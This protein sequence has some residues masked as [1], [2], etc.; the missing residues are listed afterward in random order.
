MNARALAPLGLL[1]LL[2]ACGPLEDPASVVHPG[3]EPGPTATYTARPSIDAHLPD[4]FMTVGSFTAEVDPVAGTVEFIEQ[5][6]RDDLLLAT[7]GPLRTVGQA[8]YCQ[9]T[10]NPSS[11]NAGFGLDSVAGTIGFSP[12][13]CGADTSNVIYQ[14]T[15]VFCFDAEVTNLSEN[16]RAMDVFAIIN[17]VDPDDSYAPHVFS[18]GVQEMYGANL[19][20]LPKFDTFDFDESDAASFPDQP[21]GTRPLFENLRDPL[22]VFDHGFLLPGESSVTSW[23]FRNG[24]GVFRFRGKLVAYVPEDCDG[25]DNDCDGLIDEGP[26]NISE[27][28]ACGL[29]AELGVWG[30]EIMHDQDALDSSGNPLRDTVDWD[31][32]VAAARET[33][34]QQFVI[35]VPMVSGSPDVSDVQ[36]LTDALDAANYN[37]DIVVFFDG[38]RRSQE[39]L[40]PAYDLA[41]WET[42]LNQAIAALT[43]QDS[44]YV[45][46]FVINQLNRDLCRPDRTTNCFDRADIQRFTTAL[47]ASMSGR[48]LLHLA[49]LPNDYSALAYFGDGAR[50]IYTRRNTAPPAGTRKVGERYGTRGTFTLPVSAT[51][52]PES[53]VLRFT[54]S[55]Q[56]WLGV[57][58]ARLIVTAE[59]LGETYEEVITDFQSIFL[60][61]QSV[62]LTGLLNRPVLQAATAPF[63][64]TVGFEVEITTQGYGQEA[65]VLQDVALDFN[66]RSGGALVAEP[67]YDLSDFTDDFEEFV[68][69]AMEVVNTP[70]SSF[71]LNGAVDGTFIQIIG[72]NAE[73]STYPYVERVI[74]NVNDALEWVEEDL[75]PSTTNIAMLPAV[76]SYADN[77]WN[78]WTEG[79][80]AAVADRLSG[81]SIDAIVVLDAPLSRARPTKGYFSTT[82]E[83]RADGYFVARESANATPLHGWTQALAASATPEEITALYIWDAH[84]EAGVTSTGVDIFDDRFQRRVVV[85]TGSGE[86]VLYDETAAADEGNHLT[87]ACEPG[88]VDP[89]A[90][91]PALAAIDGQCMAEVDLSPIGGSIP[92]GAALR[93]EVTL[94]AEPEGAR[95]EWYPSTER[96]TFGRSVIFQPSCGGTQCDLSDPAWAAE[97]GLNDDV[98]PA[99][100]RAGNVVGNYVDDIYGAMLTSFELTQVGTCHQP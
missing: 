17:E 71:R 24:G 33:N 97:A 22:G 9:Y 45:T 18:E 66:M 79:A 25:V 56:L 44:P 39:H 32:T 67:T 80:F 64:V 90:A 92:A 74:D 12:V 2:A 37:A 68:N 72:R 52:S 34:V 82:S 99:T 42:E 58:R 57:P 16:G 3:A 7:Q 89:T 91:E 36:S 98:Y 31:E 86:V 60:G 55:S 73:L 63:D 40:K 13:A 81:A 11:R 96:R 6:T 94:V 70:T 46:A 78:T 4:G 49:Y 69:P 87:G 26:S 53:G 41:A 54:W 28:G 14:A 20:N 75:D 21:V 27:C 85:D 43:A 15:G 61:E 29:T 5:L 48:G 10:S 84:G 77:K 35:D 100:G 23:G 59:A 51:A 76:D 93:F 95:A 38:V 30:G 65:L 8:D 83:G 88:F 1:S 19:L 47:H 62:S 50:W